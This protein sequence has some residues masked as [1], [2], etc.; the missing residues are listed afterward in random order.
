MQPFSILRSDVAASQLIERRAIGPDVRS[1]DGLYEGLVAADIEPTRGVERDFS[2][3]F[4]L[5]QAQPKVERMPDIHQARSVPKKI[6]CR[7]RIVLGLRAPQLIQRIHLGMDAQERL[8]R[9]VAASIERDKWAKRAIELLAAG[10]TKAGIVAAKKAEKWDAK[11]K[12]LE[13]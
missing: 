10:K 7:V 9:H 11:V 6:D 2:G 3:K 1:L 13:P 4:V 8:H 12:A 5:P